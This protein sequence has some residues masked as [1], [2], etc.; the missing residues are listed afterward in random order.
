MRE[1]GKRTRE[2]WEGGLSQKGKGLRLDRE[3]TDGHRQS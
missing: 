1:R 3:E 2:M